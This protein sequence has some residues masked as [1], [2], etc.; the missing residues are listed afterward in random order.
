MTTFSQ[1]VDKMVAELKR[2]DLQVEIASYL[3]Q[4]IREMHIEPTRN[5]TVLYPSNR[6][7]DQIT[8]TVESGQTWNVPKA[9]TFQGPLVA[10]YE[11]VFD[12]E[13]QPVWPKEV[14]P[15]PI[16]SKIQ[17]YFYRAGSYYVFNCFG[18]VGSL[19]TLMWYEYPPVLNYYASALRPGSY[20]EVNGWTYLSS[21]NDSD[22][23]RQQA[24]DLCT[25]WILLRWSV[26]V[27]EGVRAKVFKRL[28]DDVRARTSYSMYM[29]QRN[30]VYTG[31][32]AEFGG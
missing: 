9:S 22:L 32:M 26:V 7:E 11:N 15:G 4:T 25:N 20:D 2:P 1:L 14:K 17:E 31:E 8:T 24:Q 21:Y 6:K 16:M 3:N 12:S 18:G 27:E 30:G 5:N 13:C 28:S 10:R 23:H 19:I 29:A